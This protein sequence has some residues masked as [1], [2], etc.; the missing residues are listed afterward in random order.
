[1]TVIQLAVHHDSCADAGAEREK[2]ARVVTACGALPVLPQ[3]RQVDVVFDDRRHPDLARQD[4]AD[5]R[6]GPTLQVGRQAHEHA[7]VRID[8]AG[9]ADSNREQPIARELCLST[10]VSDSRAPCV[11]TASAVLRP[12]G[13][14]RRGGRAARRGDP[15]DRAA[16]VSDRCRCRRRT[17]SSR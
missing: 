17:R 10:E 9:H 7:G 16:C 5:R 3:D 1:M 14:G 2:D 15:R 4:G 8:N 6:P 13:L 11:V 12:A